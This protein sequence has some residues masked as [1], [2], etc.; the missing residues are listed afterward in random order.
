MNPNSPGNLSDDEDVEMTGLKDVVNAKQYT[1]L[2]P[3]ESDGDDEEQETLLIHNR[4]RERPAHPTPK[5]WP[6]I[7]NIV[8]EV[9]G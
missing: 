7:K 8:I 4:V 1:H 3:E 9:R 2:G 5:R 6:Q